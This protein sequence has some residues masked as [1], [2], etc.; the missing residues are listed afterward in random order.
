MSPE[1]IG[2]HGALLEWHEAIMPR[3]D[4]TVQGTPAD[5]KVRGCLP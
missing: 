1:V 4:V 3:A 2:R 5:E